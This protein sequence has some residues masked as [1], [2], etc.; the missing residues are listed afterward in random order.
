MRVISKVLSFKS[1][2]DEKKALRVWPTT[3]NSAFVIFA[4]SVHLFSSFFLL[5][6]FFSVLFRHELM[7][8]VNS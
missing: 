7:C 1:I 8:D 4:F 6:F 5:L 2:V 3:M